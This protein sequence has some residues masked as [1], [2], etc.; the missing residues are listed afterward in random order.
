MMESSAAVSAR[1]DR[2]GVRLMMLFAAVAMLLGPGP[3]A[4]DRLLRLF[5]PSLAEPPGDASTDLPGDRSAAAAEMLLPPLLLTGCCTVGLQAR[6]PRQSS[7]T[8]HMQP[9]Y[10]VICST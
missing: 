4:L 9:I 7:I 1:E 6:K 8:G 2:S 3:L 10:A 5:V